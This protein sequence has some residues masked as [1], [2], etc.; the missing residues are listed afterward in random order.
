[1]EGKIWTKYKVLL[2]ELELGVTRKVVELSTLSLLEL[3]DTREEVELNTVSSTR[4]GRYKRG[5]WTRNC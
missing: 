3:G 1:M 5:S 4:V 2:V